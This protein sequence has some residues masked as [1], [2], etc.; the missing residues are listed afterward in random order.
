MILNGKEISKKL[1]RKN[2]FLKDMIV[3][4]LS[5]VKVGNVKYK[6]SSTT[7]RMELQSNLSQEIMKALNSEKGYMRDKITQDMLREGKEN[8]EKYRNLITNDNQ[9]AL[10][11]LEGQ[12]DEQSKYLDKIQDTLNKF[13]IKGEDDFTNKVIDKIFN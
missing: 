13:N 6:Y 8:L 2:P 12:F 10:E 4:L 11:E 7:G 3:P 9:K 5:E 1:K